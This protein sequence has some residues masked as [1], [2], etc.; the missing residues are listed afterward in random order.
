[1]KVIDKRTKNKDEEWH[2]GDVICYWDDA[3]YKCYALIIQAS[4]GYKLVKIGG[5]Y[6]SDAGYFVLDIAY[7]DLDRMKSYLNRRYD[8]VE[9][10]NAKLLIED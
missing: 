10:A 4:Y 8:H 6:Y 9:K 7:S 3:D 1:M 5:I 2:V